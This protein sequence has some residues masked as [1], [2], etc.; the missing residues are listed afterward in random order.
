MRIEF[1]K[2]QGAGNDYIYLDCRATGLPADIAAWSRR[3]SPRH[4]A[5]GADGIICICPPTLPD[6]DATM[7]MFNADGSE[8]KMCGNGV[9]CVAEF[10]YTH[11][12]RKNVLQ[13]DTHLAG[14]KVLRR[15]CPGFWQAD[16]GR[17]SAMAADLPAVGLGEGP[18]VHAA[19]EACG[20]TWD[21]AC[22]SMGNP[23]CVIECQDPP[24][25]AALAQIGPA[26]EHNAAFPEQ[27][28][29][30]F[31]R[32]DAPDHLTMRVWERGSGETLACGTGACA[33]TAAMVLRGRCARGT[34]VRVALLG[35]ELEITVLD[36]DTVLM[37]GPAV[38]AY[39][40]AAEV[41]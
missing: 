24:T 1:T 23:H 15:L 38:T 27:T 16:M 7:Y 22:V 6:A 13:I 28:N 25:G 32:V 34:P 18:L 5:V 39:T 12:V 30:E 40:G 26:F 20:K 35:G 36:D 10:L 21:A 2:M 8:G 41:E 33:C 9:R 31:V 11:G 4:F 19:V 29:T 17:F 14:R 3:L 37:A